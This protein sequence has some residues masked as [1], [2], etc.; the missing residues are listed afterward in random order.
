MNTY[1]ILPII[2]LL[3]DWVV[4]GGDFTYFEVYMIL[5]NPSFDLVNNS[6]LEIWVFFKSICKPE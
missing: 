4:G 1:L 6:A 3:C 2:V 5:E